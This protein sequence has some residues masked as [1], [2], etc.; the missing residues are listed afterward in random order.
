MKTTLLSFATTLALVSLPTL[1]VS[2]DN[3]SELSFNAN[4]LAWCNMKEGK[5]R[6]DLKDLTKAFNRWL[7]KNDT[8]Y[9]YFFLESHYHEDHSAV[10]FYWVGS[11]EDGAGMGAGYDAWMSDNDGVGEQFA[12][13]VDCNFVMTPAT[14]V[15]EADGGLAERG[16]VW[17]RHCDID[18]DASL[19]DAVAAHRS[20]AEAMA[21][22]G[23]V[24]SSWLFL[25]GLGF[26]DADF[27]YY[28]VQAWPSFSALGTGFDNYFNKGGWKAV[29]EDQSGVLECESANLY[30]YR[31]MYSGQQD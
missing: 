25:P 26:G 21:E 10:D 6:D 27:D 1:P 18:D 2:A 12:E 23:E 15:F 29:A 16:V 30:T 13:V 22:M 7:D 9:T 20:S 17:F 19:G 5:D 28:H 11:W 14:T 4:E 31:L 8:G 24:S 3:H